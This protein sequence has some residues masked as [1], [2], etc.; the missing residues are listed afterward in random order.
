MRGVA[1]S[2]LWSGIFFYFELALLILGS[3]LMLIAHPGSLTLA[4]F[5]FSEISAAASPVS[6]RAFP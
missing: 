6:A 1:L 4:P 5:R 3:V 2:T